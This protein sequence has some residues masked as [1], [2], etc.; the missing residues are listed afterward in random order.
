MNKEC[1]NLFVSLILESGLSVELTVVTRWTAD[2][3]LDKEPGLSHIM[4][5]GAALQRMESAPVPGLA[6]FQLQVELDPVGFSQEKPVF[7]H[8]RILVFD[9]AL[10]LIEEGLAALIGQV[11]FVQ[12]LADDCKALVVSAYPTVVLI[13]ATAPLG[14][15]GFNQMHLLAV[16]VLFQEGKLHGLGT[17]RDI[18]MTAAAAYRESIFGSAIV[19]QP[20]LPTAQ[21][22]IEVRPHAHFRASLRMVI[23]AA[24]G[25]AAGAI[26]EANLAP[27]SMP[28][29]LGGETGAAGQQQDR[30][31]W[32]EAVHCRIRRNQRGMTD[33]RTRI[34]SPGSYGM[35]VV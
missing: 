25:K 10:E 30:K 11:F 22:I 20:L 8:E 21:I 3:S 6:Q 9:E 5:E 33:T 4:N 24:G 27:L 23:D 1:F 7:A 28:A 13:N 32:Q 14:K 2:C 12:L 35:T 18:G 26:G 16:P 15:I 31:P 34:R 19:D 29:L 17:I